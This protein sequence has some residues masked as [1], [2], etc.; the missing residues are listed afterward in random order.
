MSIHAL[1]PR[2]GSGTLPD[3]QERAELQ[4]SASALSW[5]VH[6]GSCLSAPLHVLQERH[7]M[8]V[9]PDSPT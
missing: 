7:G 6:T 4:G 3:T 9:S 1:Y 5:G 2:G 8:E